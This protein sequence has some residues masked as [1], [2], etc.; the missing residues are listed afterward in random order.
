MKERSLP[1][2][3][4]NDLLASQTAAAGIVRFNGIDFPI[5]F[6][7]A[8]NPTDKIIMKFHGAVKRTVRPIPVFVP[9]DPALQLN[10]HQ[11]SISDPL[12]KVHKE[13]NI[14]WFCGDEARNVQDIIGA[15]LREVAQLL[16]CKTRVYFGASGGGFAALLNSARDVG[17]VAV[18]MNPQTILQNYF[19]LTQKKYLSD[20]WPN[21]A[22]MAEISQKRVVDLREVYREAPG[23]TVI[24]IQNSADF[25]HLYRHCAPLLAAMRSRSIKDA[26]V[27]FISDISFWGKIGH[28]LIPTEVYHGWLEA[29]AAAEDASG[30][31]ILHARTEQINAAKTSAPLQSAGKAASAFDPEDIALA[32]AISKWSTL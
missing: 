30:T 29:I 14:S 19:L 32:D 26:P 8:I 17:S 3:Q 21:A 25:H 9:A 5:T 2:M 27:D 31:A 6:T 10:W 24:Y 22:T 18:A 11:L 20:C 13:L 12:L 7:P 1:T 16:E 23:N 15:F 4:L 28:Q